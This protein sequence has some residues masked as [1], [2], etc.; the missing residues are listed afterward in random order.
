[1]RE[2]MLALLLLIASGAALAEAFPVRTLAMIVA[3]EF[4]ATILSECPIEPKEDEEMACY[5]YQMDTDWHRLRWDRFVRGLSDVQWL[6]PWH[7]E[8]DY[9]SRAFLV[10]DYMYELHLVPRGT[11]SIALIIKR[12]R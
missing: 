6:T 1:M 3:T 12:V 7:N 5:L 2:L 9:H 8:R 11:T 4:D 10:E